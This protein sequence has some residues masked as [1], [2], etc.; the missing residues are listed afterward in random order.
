MVLDNCSAHPHVT[1]LKAIK[2]FFLPPN[3]TSVTQPMD[4]GIINSFKVHYKHLLITR[5]V[6]P[7]VE[8]KEKLSWTILDAM[9]ASRDA[10]NK[11]TV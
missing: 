5:G 3:T 7:A 8:K 9:Q 1:G 10:W 4:Q 6:H 2:L 11:V